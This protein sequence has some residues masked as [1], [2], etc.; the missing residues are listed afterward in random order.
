MEKRKLHAPLI[1]GLKLALTEV[2]ILGKKSDKVVAKTLKSNPKWGSRDRS[3]VAENTY[4]IVRN[5]RLLLHVLELDSL[6]NEPQIEK[7]IAAWLLLKGYSEEGNDFLVGFDIEEIKKQ[8]KVTTPKIKYSVSDE[9]DELAS[10]ELGSEKWHKEL[11]AMSLQAEVYLRVN[12]RLISR[13][14]LQEELLKLEVITESV[15]GVPSALKLQKRANLNSIKFFQNGYFEIQDA[16]SQLISEFLS[17]KP[18]ETIIDACAGAGGKTLHLADL[19]QNKGKILALDV[20]EYKLEEL[21]RRV[22]RNKISIV[23][24]NLV[25]EDFVEKHKYFADKLLLDVPCSGLGVIRRNPDAKEAVSKHFVAD[26][27]VLQKDI[28]KNYS[29]MLKPGGKMVYATCSILPSENRN[30]VDSFLEKE[31]DFSLEKDLQIWPSE[32][33]FDGFYMALINRR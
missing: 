24:T 12:L 19:M 20:E 17:P 22:K 10:E 18:G 23:E 4:E 31:P 30:Q 2:F 26:L 21:R 7:I 28:L 9:L 15:L 27:R 14:K 11:A 1:N 29:K 32:T 13:E 5:K 6:K 33:G 8:A 16:G 25:S 3:F